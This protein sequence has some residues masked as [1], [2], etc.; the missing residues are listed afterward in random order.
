MFIIIVISILR[1]KIIIIFVFLSYSSPF[2]ECLFLNQ[3][4]YKHFKIINKQNDNLDEL[5]EIVQDVPQTI[6][7]SSQL[8]NINGSQKLNHTLNANKHG[9]EFL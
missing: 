7:S 5:N 1:A 6:I 2:W 8:Q 3:D 4:T 9:I